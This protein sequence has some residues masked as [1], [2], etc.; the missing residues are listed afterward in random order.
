MKPLF[1]TIKKLPRQRT[2]TRE[3]DYSSRS[4][5]A[6]VMNAFRIRVSALSETAN[7]TSKFT[8]QNLLS[9]ELGTSP[10][11]LVPHSAVVSVPPRKKAFSVYM[12]EAHA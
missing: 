12:E 8:V 4:I 6:T 9:V 1:A 2:L 7:R 5:T 10:L 11:R 3:V